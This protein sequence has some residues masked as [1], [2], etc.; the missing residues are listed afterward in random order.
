LASTVFC[1]ST[2]V[3]RTFLIDTDTASDD[4]VALIMAL[5][6]EDVHVAAITTVAGNVG[7]A[8]ATKNALYTVELCGASVPVHA[9]ADKP[10]VRSHQ[11]ADWFHGRDGLGDHGYS[12][13]RQLPDE[14]N[15]VDAILR[16]IEANPGLVVVTLGPLTNLAL[17]LQKRP[18][19]A[20]K[21]G[22]CVVMGGA[23][24]CEGNVTPAAEYNIWVDPE[25][26]RIVMRSGLPVELIGWQ[27]CRGE[28]V[29]RESEIRQAL[30]LD[31]PIARFAMEC[32]SHARKAYLKQTGEDGISLPDPVA[33]CLAL[34]PATGTSWS[35]HCVDVETESELTRGMTVVDKLNVSGDARNRE[36][37]S[38]AR[39]AKVCWS[40]DNSRWKASL[41]RALASIVLVMV[42]VLRAQ[43]VGPEIIQ[44]VLPEDDATLAHYLIDPTR[45]E[46]SVD[47]AGNPFALSADAGLPDNLVRALGKW[48]FRPGTKDGKKVPFALFVDTQVKRPVDR[49]L[50]IVERVSERPPRHSNFGNPRIT[51]E[52]AAELE[53]KLSDDE[54]SE[55]GRSRLL[56][57]Y[58][59][60]SEPGVAETRGK[61]IAWLVRNLPGAGVLSSPAA[62]IFPAQDPDGYELVKGLWLENLSRNA[63]DPAVLGH[64]AWF[65]ELSDPE[66]TEK[67]LRPLTE[68]VGGAAAWLGR[69]YGFGASGIR[70][71]DLAT[72][73]P[74]LPEKL[75]DSG[76]W[77]HAR[78]M[79]KETNDE[80][81]LVAALSAV[82][83]HVSAGSEEFC[84]ELLGRVKRFYPE[85]KA[86][87]AT[88]ETPPPS[89]GLKTGDSLT[90][91]SLIHQVKP[92][93]PREARAK[94]I[95]G[96]V[97]FAGTIGKDG[98]VH[99]LE[100][101]SGPLALYEASR[102]AVLQWE[103]KPTSLNGVP[104]EVETSIT[105]NFTLK[106][107]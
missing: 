40:M 83:R 69:L 97:T 106:A 65:L 11:S 2:R 85:T 66:T 70:R 54:D 50:S 89:S 67:F 96:T 57:Y 87:C 62:L 25:A 6:A 30:A 82:G 48:R 63:K 61:E 98:K 71:L 20:G 84:G 55:D 64:A 95:Q 31:N 68:N 105:V 21:V 103:Y 17:A 46:V 81:V 35:E 37:W 27:L 99:D 36:I 52:N 26:A 3:L 24:C 8:Q 22:R 107:I 10:L 43:V 9:G 13:A 32:N 102:T 49:Y 53:Q 104:V 12:A 7:V 73:I 90:A 47:D 75:P 23:P 14:F 39:K 59:S 38:G 29:L 91:A 101:L 42:G 18:G 16:T 93:Y 45:V 92:V 88:G 77:M 51:P 56:R 72:G 80:R 19:I 94:R 58:A 100:L 5:R 4:A 74:V 76:Y 44:K 41:F 1:Y 33:M 28:A 34:D 78:S 60:R 15:A 86:S 79:L